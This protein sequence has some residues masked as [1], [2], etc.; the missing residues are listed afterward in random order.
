MASA[1]W[2][3]VLPY[4]PDFALDLPAGARVLTVQTQFA[5]RHEQPVLWAVVDPDAPVAPRRFQ[6]LGTGARELAPG[7]RY[8]G[9]L[10]LTG[11]TLVLHIFEVTPGEDKPSLRAF[12]DEDVAGL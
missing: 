3:W 11:G 7:A 8:V 9:T 5:G 4:E 10:Q 12:G 6:L 2:K 1:I